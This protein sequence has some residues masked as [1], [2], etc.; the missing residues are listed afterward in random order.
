MADV[1]SNENRV[2]VAATTHRDLEFTTARLQRGQIPAYPC[3][4][5]RGL[6]EALP[7]GAGCVVIT[8]E[9]L[10]QDGAERLL[11]WLRQQPA[12]SELPFVVLARTDADATAAAG[13]LSPLTSAAV[14][15]RP[16]RARTLSSAVKASL[17]A[18]QRQYE[19]RRHLESLQAAWT[20]LA[21]ANRAK[22]EFLAVLAHELRNPLAPIRSAVQFL[23]AGTSQDPARRKAQEMIGRQLSHLVRLVDD[24]LDVSRIALGRVQVKR[25]LIVLQDVLNDSIEAVRPLIEAAQHNL[26][27]K[28]PDAPVYIEGDSTRLTQ[29]FQNLLNNAARY[30]PGGGTI[31]IAASVESGVV[32]VSVVDNG[33]GIRADL[34]DKLFQPFVQGSRKLLRSQGG[35][36]VG[37]SLAQRLVELHEGALHAE[38]EGEG[39]GSVFR[40]RLPVSARAPQA[41]PIQ[42]AASP[43]PARDASSP[44]PNVPPTCSCRVLVVDDN[45]DA[46][47]SLSML[48][49]LEGAKV[50][51]AHDGFEA[52]A[53][54]R[55]FAADVI[56]LDIG[57]P[58]MDG[59]AVCRQL[60]AMPRGEDTRILAV[61]GWG[62]QEDRRK[63]R[64]AG[65]DAHLVKPV[66]PDE[67]TRILCEVSAGKLE[68][69]A[70]SLRAN[71]TD[72]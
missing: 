65:F 64:E 13:M 66:D 26:L 21:L 53:I 39:H 32:S 14:L 72:T 67:L 7:R 61:T 38:S 6:L 40:V 2:L 69:R 4:Q 42:I 63:T 51:Q 33:I 71:A 49:E 25:S 58:G 50:R 5:L 9:T 20:E 1:E 30:T 23:T 35:L 19:I 29:V 59:Y 3:T 34:M 31:A 62:Q 68:A 70:Q 56:V 22:D 17:R 12:W 10:R 57:M 55:E 27:L 24:L 43:E 45:I 41:E 16:V 15:E 28:F 18:R 54:A 60:R 44:P 11:E 52:L 36:G 47:E 46:A 8:A 48:L 37:L